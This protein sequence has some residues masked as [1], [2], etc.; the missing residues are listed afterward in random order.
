MPWEQK[1]GFFELKDLIE[2]LAYFDFSAVT[3][4]EISLVKDQVSG[5]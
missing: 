4:L 5:V 2:F 3:Y 1:R